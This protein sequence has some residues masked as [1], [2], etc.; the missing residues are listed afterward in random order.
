M[1]Q[2]WEYASMGIH[3]LSPSYLKINEL[4]DAY[5]DAGWELVSTSTVT[6]GMNFFFKRPL[7]TQK[8]SNAD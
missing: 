1:I 7:V 3:H 4:L 2:K 8:E 5:G 6:T